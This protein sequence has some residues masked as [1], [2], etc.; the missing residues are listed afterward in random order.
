LVD[1]QYT[2]SE[3]ESLTEAVSP[4]S[5]EDV[6][7]MHPLRV[8]HPLDIPK[9][10]FD[11]LSHWCL[12]AYTQIYSDTVLTESLPEGIVVTLDLAQ[13]KL[14]AKRQGAQLALI[15][16]STDISLRK[17]LGN[18][19]ISYFVARE[20]DGI[21]V[22]VMTDNAPRPIASFRIPQ[23]PPANPVTNTFRP[24]LCLQAGAADL[25]G[26][27]VSVIAE[28]MTKRMNWLN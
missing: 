13:G 24:Q 15:G 1:E 23:K 3:I 6:G 10:A 22:G 26:V 14:S 11:K 27:A 28:S 19:P 20:G 9:Q 7:K 16:G 8:G 4:V 17:I 2:T 18:V 12:Y 21:L 5:T 25:G